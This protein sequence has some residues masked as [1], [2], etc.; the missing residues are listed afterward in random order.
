MD[1]HTHYMGLI[2]KEHKKLK[3]L[4]TRPWALSVWLLSKGE[5]QARRWFMRSICLAFLAVYTV[6]VCGLFF[7][8][9]PP[10]P[11]T[12]QR[13]V[14]V[15]V[16]LLGAVLVYLLCAFA[17][18][19]VF[20]LL[21]RKG[22]VPACH[23]D[24]AEITKAAGESE[25]FK[26]VVV[27]LLAREGTGQ[28]TQMQATALLYHYRRIHEWSVLEATRKLGLEDLEDATGAVSAAHGLARAQDLNQALPEAAE[29]EAA[30]PRF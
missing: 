7:H 19:A 8:F 21:G 10:P 24:M 1:L 30:K 3:A 26:N 6:V 20:P 5:D 14:A 12:G 28:V 23:K 25:W 9:M 13:V 2:T 16:Y 29:T 27:K 17:S 15:L 4:K 18:D 22:M 11:D